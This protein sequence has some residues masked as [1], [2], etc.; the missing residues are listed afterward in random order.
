MNPLRT[1]R[2][3]FGGGYYLMSSPDSVDLVPCEACRGKGLVVCDVCND[4]GW[5]PEMDMEG[6]YTSD[7]PCTC[8]TGHRLMRA[9]SQT[10]ETFRDDAPF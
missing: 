2:E 3:C 9:V 1:C 7:I 8:A 4:S 5:M 6:H 10:A